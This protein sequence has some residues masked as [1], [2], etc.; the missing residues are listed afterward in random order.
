MPE[1]HDER[2]SGQ[3]H[4]CGRA[5]G[6]PRTASLG[7]PL[8][9]QPL[10]LAVVQ[11]AWE[12]GARAGAQDG[13]GALERGL[14]QHLPAPG[15]QAIHALAAIPGWRGATAPAWGRQWQPGGPSTKARTHASSCRV[16]RGVWMPRRVPSARD[17]ASWVATAGWGRAGADGPSTKPSGR[18]GATCGAARGFFRS[19]RRHRHGLA[20]RAGGKVAATATA[21]SQSA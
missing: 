11:Q 18:A 3:G 20:T 19:I 13:A 9:P 5:G 17:S 15:G 21:C 16:A 14:P 4:P 6:P 2:S 1:P 7:E 12:G 10:A 8:A